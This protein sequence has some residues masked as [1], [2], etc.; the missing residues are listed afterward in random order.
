MFT[1]KT[2]L[3]QIQTFNPQNNNLHDAIFSPYLNIKEGNYIGKNGESSQIINPFINHRNSPL[4]QVEKTEEI[5][6]FGAEKYFNRREVD[7]PRVSTK[8]LPQRDESMAI[9]TRKY[10]VEYGTPSISSVSTWNSQSALL[11]SEVR[12]SLRNS[13]EKVH[14]K[15]VLSSLG[16]TCSCSD[17]NSVDINDH[18]SEISFNKKT[19]NVQGK[20]TPKKVFNLGLDNDLS[21]KIRKPSSELFI[22]KDVYFQKQE[23]LR[24]GGLNSEKNSLASNSR[25]HLPSLDE[26]KTPRKSLEVF[27]SPKPILINNKRLIFP[28]KM[29]EIVD[30]D[31]ASDASSDLF[32]IESL[33]GKSSNNFLTRQTS[34]A[35]SSCVSPNNYA[36][37][38]ASIEWSVVTASAAVMSDCEDQMSEFTIRSPIKTPLKPKITRETPKRRPG[39][40]LGCKSHKA[41]RVAGDAFITYEKQSL[42]PKIGNRNKNSTNSQVARFPG[43][44]N[45]GAKTRHGQQHGYNTTPPL[46]A[47]N[48]PHASKLLYI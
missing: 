26:V 24:I 18:A 47:S 39:T 17:K 29:E 2:S 25:N 4:H 21:V 6:V 44:T 3:H 15:S 9:E 33:K 40:L 28:S 42:S 11:K 43:E 14:A 8:Y 37:S 5:G 1:S 34:D 22:N 41:V 27:G 32:E 13:K 23:K 16:L 10:Q 38:E 45:I 7:T 36:P 12:N 31:A 48:S 46:M 20:T 35:A 30:D 19:C